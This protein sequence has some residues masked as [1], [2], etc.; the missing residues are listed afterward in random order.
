M[1]YQAY[2]KM[3]R[4]IELEHNLYAYSVEYSAIVTIDKGDYWTPPCIEWD[5]TIEN[6]EREHHACIGI[7]EVL[8]K[9]LDRNTMMAIEEAIDSDID[10]NCENYF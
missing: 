10:S 6:I 8:Y 7:E 1:Q 2:N 5:F 4:T 3:N 9:D